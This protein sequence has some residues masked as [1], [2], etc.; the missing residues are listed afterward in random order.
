MCRLLESK[1][2]VT[3]FI[4]NNP[5]TNVPQR[6]P[7]ACQQNCTSDLKGVNKG[8]CETYLNYDSSSEMT[9]VS[10]SSVLFAPPAA[11]AALAAGGE[12]FR[13]LR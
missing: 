7:R 3:L 10:C 5:Q 11:P 2:E 12:I 9:M 4:E 8:V 13:Y 6:K 1:I